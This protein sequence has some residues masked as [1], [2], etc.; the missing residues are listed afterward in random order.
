MLRDAGVFNI[1]GCGICQL[2][3]LNHLYPLTVCRRFD[4]HCNCYYYLLCINDEL[5]QLALQ[6]W[7]ELMVSY[8]IIDPLNSNLRLYFSYFLLFGQQ[9]HLRFIICFS[10]SVSLRIYWS[11]ILSDTFDLVE[12]DASERVSNLSERPSAAIKERS[13]IWRSKLSMMFLHFWWRVICISISL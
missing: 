5:F 2:L 9:F 3:D 7:V 6:C 13:W 11:L 8:L 10:S 4:P 12:M 1:V